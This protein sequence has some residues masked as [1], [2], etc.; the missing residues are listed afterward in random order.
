MNRKGFTLIELLGTIVIIA[1]VI[2]GSVFG[3]INLVGQSKEKGNNLTKSSI[4]KSAGVYAEEKNNDEDFWNRIDNRKGYE[5]EYF[6]VT[7]G[8]L[9]NKGLIDKDINF[10]EL[11]KD[12]ENPI[13]E[14][15][16]VGI[17]KDLATL[18][19]SNPT[20]LNL[21]SNDMCKV[22]EGNCSE[23]AIIYGACTGNIYNE[24]INSNPTI[25][26][27]KSYTDEIANME[28]TDVTGDENLVITA[29]KC[30]YSDSTAS[31]N[32]EGTIKEEE[33]NKKCTINGLE[34]DKEYYIKVCNET[35]AGSTACS[36][37]YKNKTKEVKKP[38]I[39]LDKNNIRVKITYDDADIREGT[40][41]Y[42]FK[43]NI[44]ATSSVEVSKC[45]NDK[46]CSGSTTTVEKDI[47]YLTTN[48]EIYLIYT[49]STT[50]GK[51]DATTCDNSKNCNTNEKTFAI[52][53]TTFIKG[54]ADKIGGGTS[55][56]SKLCMA[57]TKDTCNITSPTIEKS[58]YNIIGWN[59][60]SNANTPTWNVSESKSVSKNSTYYPIVSII[61]YTITYN[62]NGGSGAPSSQTKNHGVNITLSSTIPT[63]S[64]YAFT[65]WNTNKNGT[66]TSYAKGATYSTDATV[67][68]YAQWKVSNYTL[69]YDTQGGTSVPSQTVNAGSSTKV[70][71][72]KPTKAGN[73]FNHWNTKKDDSGD[74]YK[75]GDSIV[76]NSNITLYAI[77]DYSV[78]IV[79]CNNVFPDDQ[80]PWS[81][82]S[83]SVR[84]KVTDDD[85]D[86][87]K[88]YYNKSYYGPFDYNT[89][90]GSFTITGAETNMIRIYAMDKSGHISSNQMPEWS[91]PTGTDGILYCYTNLDKAPPNTPIAYL[92]KHKPSGSDTYIWDLSDTTNIKDFETDC[93]YQKD[94]NMAS[95]SSAKIDRNTT[96]EQSC[97]ITAYRKNTNAFAKFT[98]YFWGEDWFGDYINEDTDMF[99]ARKITGISNE[100]YYIMKE[101]NSSGRTCTKK[102]GYGE[103]VTCSCMNGAVKDEI[104]VVDKVGL[105]SKVLTVYIEWK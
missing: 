33:G 6:C 83:G 101:Y 7:I 91:A 15:T 84:V 26:D 69:T 61:K 77:Y 32:N 40:A 55:N 73:K 38:N 53:K 1:L 80:T 28:I 39:T 9:Q 43:S 78:P 57:E 95:C 10:K 23:K 19:K 54:N 104:Y 92:R 63:R 17:R 90:N 11:Y 8:E 81:S 74:S 89:T 18:T 75:S 2:G 5:G 100:D 60:N 56:I 79:S 70:T 12:P 29:T 25:K 14:K 59:E 49:D 88:V 24:V 20:I 97:T 67:T 44:N 27:G 98:Y 30:Y 13:N 66:G 21:K 93:C 58:G 46:N 34:D 3:I 76:L 47:E 42:Y 37:V 62:A 68:L 71:S 4:E 45:D 35:K 99:E 72:T 31:L 51:V 36:G 50:N 48:K 65:G 103:G 94:H 22:K 102:C 64:G 85:G 82:T 105:Q 41:K 96:K 86:L 87:D 52:Y 16:Y